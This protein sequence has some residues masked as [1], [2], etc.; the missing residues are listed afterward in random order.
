MKRTAESNENLRAH[1]LILSLPT[2]SESFRGLFL[3]PSPSSLL[4]PS[5]YHPFLPQPSQNVRRVKTG[6]L[7]ERREDFPSK[8]QAE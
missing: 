4:L 3:L 7:P 1:A 6:T 8:S 5:L 2:T